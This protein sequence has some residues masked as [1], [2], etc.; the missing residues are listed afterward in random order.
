MSDMTLLSDEAIHRAFQSRSAA[1]VPTGLASAIVAETARTRQRAAWPLRLRVPW[2]V[3]AARPML[4]FTVISLAVVVGLF[5]VVGGRVPTP[6]ATPAPTASPSATP[7]ATALVGT[8]GQAPDFR[9]PFSYVVPRGVT[10]ETETL[11]TEPTLLRE[12][13]GLIDLGGRPPA[14][15]PDVI[16]RGV[17]V[18]AIA[19]PVIH[20]CE[21]IIRRRIRSGPAEFLE[22]LR[23]Q[24]GTPLGTPTAATLDG[25]PA[26]TATLPDN[27]KRPIVETPV[28]TLMPTQPPGSTPTEPGF[29]NC[30][31]VPADAPNLDFHYRDGAGMTGW[32]PLFV[33]SQLIVADID[34]LTVM[35]QIWA[36]NQAEFDSWLPTA[37]ELVDSIDFAHVVEPSAAPASHLSQVTSFAR[38]FEY[39]LPDS[40][41]LQTTVS[42]PKIVALVDRHGTPPGAVPGAEERGVTILVIDS[43]FIHGCPGQPGRRR[44]RNTPA[45]FLEDLRVR[46]G[47]AL[48]PPDATLLD[49]RPAL[50]TTPSQEP[51]PAE[52]APAASFVD[53]PP[54]IGGSDLHFDDEVGEGAVQLFVPSR[55]I[56]ARIDGLTLLVEIWA[57]SQVEFD[58]WLPTAMELVDSIHF[59]P[60]PTQ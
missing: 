10:L 50:V 43:P 16:G 33:P 37:M 42:D 31:P 52:P 12:A 19:K 13:F 38:P 32:I 14:S 60:A 27:T 6:T 53:C 54:E 2:S 20:G 7:A 35:V 29:V 51:P 49:G 21:D 41:T 23:V 45:E 24:N 36:E 47:N 3:P 48:S 46:N 15:S 56:V 4:L 8:P 58:A 55:L 18:I 5:S 11:E 26:L 17:R 59:L 40:G 30:P 28:Q 1:G 9:R 57:Q 25:R 34:G 44:I 39:A 22:D